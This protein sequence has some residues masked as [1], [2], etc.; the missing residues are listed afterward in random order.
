MA[1]D[2]DTIAA[3]MQFFWLRELIAIAIAITKI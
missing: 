2:S 3:I 1:F